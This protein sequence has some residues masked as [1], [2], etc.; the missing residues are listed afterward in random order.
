M[1]KQKILTTCDLFDHRY[2]KQGQDE[3]FTYKKCV[4]CGQQKEIRYNGQT[5]KRNT[6]KS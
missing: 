4:R 2:I 5:T 6:K 1:I 3:I